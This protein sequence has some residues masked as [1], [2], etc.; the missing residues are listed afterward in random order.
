MPHRPASRVCIWW[1]RRPDSP[2]GAALDAGCGTG[3]DAVWLARQ[4]WDVTAVDISPTAV[5]HARTVAAPEPEVTT[6]ICWLA[7]DLTVWQPPRRY[8]LVV[9]LYVHPAVP[10][11]DFVAR[12][13]AAVA[14]GGTLLVI[15]HDRADSHSAA[16]APSTASIDSTTVV[17]ALGPGGWDLAVAE[18]RTQQAVHGSTHLGMADLVVG[19]RRSPTG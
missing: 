4:G 15:G 3:A 2:R 8:D 5:Q 18:I 12:L 11:G 17:R 6:R 19:A 10:F 1:P 7:A 9:S 14:P 13:G 16:Q